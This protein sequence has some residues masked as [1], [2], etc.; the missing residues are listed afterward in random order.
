MACRVRYL[1]SAGIHPR[2]IPGVDGLAAAFPAHW[3]FYASLQCMP[4]GSSPIEIDSMVVMDDRVLLL[5]IKDWN[6]PLTVNGDQW[7]VNDKTRGRSPVD[8]VNMKAKKMASFFRQ[9]IPG[10]GP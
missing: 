5:E 9:T 8:S 1:N 2:E 6:G 4:K 7:L 3:L 10:F